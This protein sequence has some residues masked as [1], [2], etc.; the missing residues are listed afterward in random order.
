MVTFLRC[1]GDTEASIDVVHMRRSDEM[2][3]QTIVKQTFLVQIHI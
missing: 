3:F 1:R 2:S